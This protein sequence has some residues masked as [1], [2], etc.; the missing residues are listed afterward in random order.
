M[1]HLFPLK[2]LPAKAERARTRIWTT[3]KSGV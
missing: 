2:P 1:A 3:I